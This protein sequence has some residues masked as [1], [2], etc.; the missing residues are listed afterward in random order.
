MV[1][2][3]CFIVIRLPSIQKENGAPASRDGY[4]TPQLTGR[5]GGGL[6][7]KSTAI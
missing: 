5:R 2:G 3:K 7:D 4:E 6:R 1:T